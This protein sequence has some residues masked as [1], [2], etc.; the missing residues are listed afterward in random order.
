MAHKNQHIFQPMKYHLPKKSISILVKLRL[1]FCD[2][3]NDKVL[4]T[5]SSYAKSL[6]GT[7]TMRI[8]QLGVSYQYLT[9][10][11]QWN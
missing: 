10:N 4:I 9:Q 3:L 7:K 8:L 5:N 2:E 6:G 11:F 1:V